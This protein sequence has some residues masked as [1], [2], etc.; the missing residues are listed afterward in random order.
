M[1]AGKPSLLLDKTIQM[2][3]TEGEVATPLYVTSSHR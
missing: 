1:E 2:L 3:P